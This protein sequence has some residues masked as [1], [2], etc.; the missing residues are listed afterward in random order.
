VRD[1]HPRD[2]LQYEDY[3]SLRKLTCLELGLT[4]RPDPI[5]QPEQERKVT[6]LIQLGTTRLSYLIQILLLKK[7]PE[8]EPT[9]LLFSKSL[10]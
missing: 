2:I 1:H 5:V 8:P 3:E 7:R 4:Y 10:E 6:Q 9:K